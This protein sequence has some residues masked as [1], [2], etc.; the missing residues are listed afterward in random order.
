[1]WAPTNKSYGDNP[2]P[3]TTVIYVGAWATF[4]R[5]TKQVVKKR[6]RMMVA[7]PPSRNRYQPGGLAARCFTLRDAPSYPARSVRKYK[8]WLRRR[9][10][11]LTLIFSLVAP[12]F[13]F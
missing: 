4:E 8:I 3:S 11:F 10:M 9:G 12:I 6:G 2:S 5:L 1:M 7:T 13:A